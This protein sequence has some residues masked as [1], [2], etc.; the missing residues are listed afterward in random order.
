MKIREAERMSGI[1]RT[2]IR[3]IFDAAPDGAINLG[4]GQ[5][6]LPTPPVASMGLPGRGGTCQ[7]PS[8]VASNAPL[9]PIVITE[10]CVL[11]ARRR[12]A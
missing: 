7:A 5:P 6:D 2:L 8:R 3:R 4:L 10:A 1:D 12:L 11:W 9:L